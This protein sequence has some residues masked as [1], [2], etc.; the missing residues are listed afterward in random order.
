MSNGLSSAIR[1]L[2]F[3]SAEIRRVLHCR[4]TSLTAEYAGGTFPF[5]TCRS[6]LAIPAV[7]TN[8]NWKRVCVFLRQITVIERYD[9]SR[10]FS[11]LF[12]QQFNSMLSINTSTFNTSSTPTPVD[13]MSCIFMFLF[14]SARWVLWIHSDSGNF[15]FQGF[16]I[17]FV[18]HFDIYTRLSNWFDVITDWCYISIQSFRWTYERTCTAISVSRLLTIL[19]KTMISIVH[20]VGL[21]RFHVSIKVE[22]EKCCFR[23]GQE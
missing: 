11:F 22:V 9:R 12:F 18:S 8:Q 1:T 6:R 4:F 20:I 5:T 14:F 10:S 13:S 3:C 2:V 21:C 15:C 23:G 17:F 19:R 7:S 16:L